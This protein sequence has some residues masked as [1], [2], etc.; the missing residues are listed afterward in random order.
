MYSVES[1]LTKQTNINPNI[2]LELQNLNHTAG[3]VVKPGK[4][5]C[6]HISKEDK[7]FLKDE[8]PIFYHIN[9]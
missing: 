3:S 8:R 6:C 7:L 9:E 2:E 1:Q 4:R 5:I